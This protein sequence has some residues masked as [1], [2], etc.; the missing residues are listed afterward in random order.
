MILS[1]NKTEIETNIQ[2]S[3]Q[4]FKINSS[5]KAFK[6]LSSS[7]YINKV[8]AIIR[9]LSTNAYDAHIDAKNP[10]PFEIYLPNRLTPFFKIRDFGT[11]MSRDKIET[12]YTTYFLSDKTESNEFVGALGLGSKSPFSYVNSFTVESYVNG[13]KYTYLAYLNEDH[14]PCINFISDIET[15]ERNGVAIQFSVD[16]KDFDIFFN[17]AKEVFMYFK[18]KPIFYGYD[19]LSFPSITF[20]YNSWLIFQKMYKSNGLTIIQGNVA[21]SVNKNEINKYTSQLKLDKKLNSI[22]SLFNSMYNSNLCIT[23]PIGTCDISPSRESLDYTETTLKNIL[24]Y[25]EKIFDDIIEIINSIELTNYETVIK[26]FISSSFLL[27]VIST[28][29]FFDYIPINFIDQLSEI[30]INIISNT[31]IY[32]LKRLRTSNK[33]FIKPINYNL[34][35]LKNSNSSFRIQTIIEICN[36]FENSYHL[37]I[38]DEFKLFHI[39]KAIRAYAE[40]K[41]DYTSSKNRRYIIILSKNIIQNYQIPIDDNL[42]TAIQMIPKSY[43]SSIKN[44][45]T[46]ASINVSTFHLSQN[47]WIFETVSRYNSFIESSE[48]IYYIPIN[49]G[50]FVDKKKRKYSSTQISLLIKWMHEFNQFSETVYMIAPS[51]V[52]SIFFKKKEKINFIEYFERYIQNMSENDFMSSFSG[53]L[54][55]NGRISETKKDNLIFI[56]TILGKKYFANFDL[57]STNKYSKT[58]Y[59]GTYWTDFG[60]NILKNKYFKNFDNVN[61]QIEKFLDKYPLLRYINIDYKRWNSDEYKKDIEIYIKAKGEEND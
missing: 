18:N 1:E 16:V 52:R 7:L 53:Y 47:D 49:N 61:D 22:L 35:S 45:N 48:R 55:V 20:E 3:P 12:L 25:Y 50:K 56:N 46:Q 19:K 23:V 6:I 5:S 54:F 14:I 43:R 37:E 21:Y 15:D 9:E 33:F 60:F 8:K 27:R 39:Q 11:G 59:Q 36:I 32:F 13:H 58:I 24:S 51:I 38:D 28:R 2:M 44:N 17:E 29:E 31:S 10:E 42:S 41:Y 26:L 4:V 57:F 34:D 30:I 40:K